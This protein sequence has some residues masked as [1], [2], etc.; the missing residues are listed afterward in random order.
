[1]MDRRSL[2]IGAAASTIV[3]PSRAINIQLGPSAPMGIPRRAFVN[4]PSLIKQDCPLWC[5]AASI[6]MIFASN[7]H[8][9]PNQ[10]VII[11]KAFAGLGL[12]CQTGTPSGISNLLSGEWVD[13]SGQKFKSNVVAN[14]DIFSGKFAMDNFIIVNELSQDRPLLYCNKHHAMVVV[15]T[16]Y[17]DTPM[18][19]NVQQ[20]LVMDPYPGSPNIHPLTIPEMIPAHIGGEYS[21][22]AAVYIS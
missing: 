14:Y 1:M 13:A 12:V 11:R 17:V 19:P 22:L 5:W 8:P 21:Y 16:D 15:S 7:G 2:L 3:K 6:A 18:G 4:H 10:E 9:L 20:V